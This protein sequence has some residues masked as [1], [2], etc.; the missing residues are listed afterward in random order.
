MD[1]ITFCVYRASLYPLSFFVL[2]I[3][4]I[5]IIILEMERREKGEVVLSALL[6]SSCRKYFKFNKNIRLETSVLAT[7]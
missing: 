2:S 3:I 5:I 7:I 4:F 6:F 1:F